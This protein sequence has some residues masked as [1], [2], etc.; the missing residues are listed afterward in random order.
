MPRI[1]LESYDAEQAEG[2]DKSMYHDKGKRD[3]ESAC[4]SDFLFPR[5]KFEL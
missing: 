1:M 5:F 4:G 3:T 2:K